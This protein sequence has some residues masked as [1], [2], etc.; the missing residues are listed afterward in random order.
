MINNNSNKQ[1]KHSVIQIFLKSIQVIEEYGSF[2]AFMVM[3]ILV[4]LAIFLR[5]TVNFESS[6]WEE[7]ARFSSIW[8]YMLAIAVASQE[9]SHLRAGFLEKYIHSEKSK[10]MLEVIFKVIM[11][12]C[13]FIFIWW[14]IEQL[15]WIGATKQKSLV[16]MI[17]MWFV[18]LAFVVG[19]IFAFIHTIYYLIDYI[20]KYRESLK[21]DTK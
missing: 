11:M 3:I 4:N 9:D 12:I 15:N 8:M 20:K 18:Y 5:M 13:I 19:G 7:I 2:M 17:N 1:S 21:G 16:L 6:S 14:S 10:Y